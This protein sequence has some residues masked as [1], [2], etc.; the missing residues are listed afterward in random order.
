MDIWYLVNN[1]ELIL[2]NRQVEHLPTP[3]LRSTF[4]LLCYLTSP[5]PLRLPALGWEACSS[6]LRNLA[7]PQEREGP[8]NSTQRLWAHQPSLR[9]T[10]S[11]PTRPLASLWSR[12]SPPTS[13]PPAKCPVLWRR[14]RWHSL[15]HVVLWDLYQ[16]IYAMNHIHWIWL[17]GDG[18]GFTGNPQHR[19]K[20]DHE[21]KSLPPGGILVV[22]HW[23]G[24]ILHKVEREEELE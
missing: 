8:V 23:D 13:T 20:G 16:K 15:K 1:D 22:T 2:H 7:P 3:H 18:L 14:S 21:T 10:W 24:D 12:G 4:S 19:W 9:C 5:P 6:S 17:K 11:R